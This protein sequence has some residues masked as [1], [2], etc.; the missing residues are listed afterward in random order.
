MIRDLCSRSTFG[1]LG[2]FGTP[3][4]LADEMFAATS[5]RATPQLLNSRAHAEHIIQSTQHS[6]HACVVTK[7]PCTCSR[8]CERTIIE[9]VF[10]NR[11]CA[12]VLFLKS[13]SLILVVKIVLQHISLGERTFGSAASCQKPS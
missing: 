13:I 1:G 5:V 7:L 10:L 8:R 6:M 11:R 9:T 3:A 4:H 12:L 2:I